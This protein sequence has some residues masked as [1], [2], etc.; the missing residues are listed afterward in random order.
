MLRRHQK[1][2]KT[3]AYY[4]FFQNPDAFAQNLFSPPNNGEPGF[5]KKAADDFFKKTYE[6]SE[7]NYSYSPPPGLPRPAK[8][9]IP[10]NLEKPSEDEISKIIWKKKNNSS[11]GLNGIGYL[12]YKRCPGV[13]QRLISLLQRIWVK[14]K[15]PT[16]WCV[17]RIKLLAKTDDTSEPSLMRPIPVLIV[18]GRIFFSVFQS[19]LSSTMLKNGYLVLR[20]QKASLEGVS[21][22]IEHATTMSAVLDNAKDI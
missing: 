8:P 15:I 9:S 2:A 10:F 17:A 1:C 19:R 20:V 21:G 7:R 12:V 22:C 18:E 14:K 16:S 11:P 13:K 4:K 3:K 6:D 5:D